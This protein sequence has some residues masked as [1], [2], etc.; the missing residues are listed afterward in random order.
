MVMTQML[1]L[2]T[3]AAPGTPSDVIA[4]MVMTTSRGIYKPIVLRP[5]PVPL[6]VQHGAEHRPRIAE[7]SERQCAVANQEHCR[8]RAR[9]VGH[10]DPSKGQSYN[11]NAS[12]RV[13]GAIE[14]SLDECGA[15]G[16]NDHS[17]K[18]QSVT[19]QRVACEWYLGLWRRKAYDGCVMRL[20]APRVTNLNRGP[21]PRSRPVISNKDKKR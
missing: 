13:F 11:P 14:H 20:L 5:R 17:T 18:A 10:L 15:K 7:P 12:T 19:C 1:E 6:A 3:T 4:R 21:L 2:H 8:S 9:R 16:R